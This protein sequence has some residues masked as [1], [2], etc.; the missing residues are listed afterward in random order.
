MRHLQRTS[1]TPSIARQFWADLRAALL[2]MRSV[3]PFRVAK[4]GAP[5]PRDAGAR[6]SVGL[7]VGQSEDWRF[8]AESDC[9]G[10]HVQGFG[11]SWL[12][13]VDRVHPECDV[14]AHIREDAPDVWL[15]GA[16]ALGALAGLALGR[17]GRAALAGAAIGLLVGGLTQARE[18]DA[19]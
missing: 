7:P 6:P 8:P 16:G 11:A 1:P 5:H 12:V 13:H 2:D 19:R 15:A 17:S 3:T 10:V 9:R 18:P 14:L 4:R